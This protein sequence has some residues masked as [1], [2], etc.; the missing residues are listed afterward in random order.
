[1]AVRAKYFESDS[2][3]TRRDEMR[4]A[5]GVMVICLAASLAFATTL[6][7]AQSQSGKPAQ[8]ASATHTKAKVPS[9]PIAP[10]NVNTGLWQTTVTAKYTG[11]PPQIAAA[12]NP[13][14]TSKGC[15]KPKDLTSDAWTN[16]LAGLKCSSVTV[17]K[18]T[19]TDMD[20]QGK[21]CNAGNGMT[22]EGH[23]KF[24]V[25][26]SEHVTGT[27][28]VTFSGSTPF[29]GNGPVHMLANYDSKWIGATCPADMN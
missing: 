22:A 16:G 27:M 1:M 10:P 9:A 15:V 20:V 5:I 18:S 11:L 29:G 4:K 21:G 14:M 7:L 26:D 17:L 23:G 28:D 12:I 6:L 8:D 24:H 25:L 13:T 3:L 2:K 19:G